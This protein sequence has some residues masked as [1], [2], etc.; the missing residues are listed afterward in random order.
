MDGTCVFSRT[1]VET[2][3]ASVLSVFILTVR[4]TEFPHRIGIF[5]LKG[6]DRVLSSDRSDEFTRETLDVRR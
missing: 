6:N 1:D 3:S 4:R 5:G 2:I